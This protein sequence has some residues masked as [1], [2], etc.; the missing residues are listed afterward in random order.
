MVD[1]VAATHE[2]TTEKTVKEMYSA[3][4][5]A[6]LNADDYSRVIYVDGQVVKEDFKLEAYDD[7]SGERK[8][9]DLDSTDKDDLKSI[10][11]STDTTP[12]LETGNGVLTQVFIIPPEYSY[13][14]YGGKVMSREGEIIISLIHTYLAEVTNVVDNGDDYTVTVRY[15]TKDPANVDNL[16]A[17]TAEYDKDMSFGEKLDTTTYVERGD[18]VSVQVAYNQSTKTMDI[19]S[20]SEVTVEEGVATSAKIDPESRGGSWLAVDGE[21]YN[22]AFSMR[23]NMDT[24]DEMAPDGQTDITVFFDEYGYVLG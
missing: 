15:E 22:F 20:L 2:F 24:D 12:F 21:T 5:S 4:G 9:L 1:E 6:A 14:I 23:G 16:G 18:R 13:D 11:S 8:T 7:V 10:L 17:W 3:V 19:Q